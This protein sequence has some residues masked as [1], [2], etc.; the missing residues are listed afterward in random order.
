M[1]LSPLCIIFQ[2]MLCV[3][4]KSR[5]GE[6]GWYTQMV[7]MTW[8]LSGLAMKS[9]GRAISLV[10]SA[11]GPRKLVPWASPILFHSTNHFQYRHVE[12]G[13]GDLGPLYVNGWN[14]IIGWVMRKACNLLRTSHP[15]N[16]SMLAT[17]G[18]SY[19]T[20]FVWVLYYGFMDNK[21]YV[22]HWDDIDQ[23]LTQ[24]TASLLLV[25]S[26]TTSQSSLLAFVVV[27]L[28]CTPPSV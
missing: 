8:S 16:N 2:H 3:S 19:C 20:L 10:L 15:S 7:K 5:T 26:E 14:E 22:G 13:S 18:E 9:L 23:S 28:G 4:R 17:C 21:S 27:L 11:N 24:I 1:K 25:G 12:E 6:V